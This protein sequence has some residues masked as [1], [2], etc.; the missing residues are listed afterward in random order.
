MPGGNTAYEQAMADARA[1]AAAAARQ[2]NQQKAQ[3]S[4]LAAQRQGNIAAANKARQAQAQRVAI[5][6]SQAENAARKAEQKRQ[7]QA[8]SRSA[9]AKRTADRA[10][11]RQK[12]SDDRAEAKREADKAEER[13]KDRDNERNRQESNRATRERNER[14]NRIEANEFASAQAAAANRKMVKEQT[15]GRKAASDKRIADEKKAAEKIKADAAAR[16]KLNMDLMATLMGKQGPRRGSRGLISDTA[17]G[18]G[19]TEILSQIAQSKLKL[20]SAVNRASGKRADEAVSTQDVAGQQ[21]T[22]D[23]KKPGWYSKDARYS[24][25]QLKE[26]NRLNLEALDRIKNSK[27]VKDATDKTNNAGDSKDATSSTS[28]ETTTG[29]EYSGTY[30]EALQKRQE[31]LDAGDKVEAKKWAIVARR[32]GDKKPSLVRGA[33]DQQIAKGNVFYGTNIPTAGYSKEQIEHFNGR[34]KADLAAGD[35]DGANDAIFSIAYQKKGLGVTAGRSQGQGQGNPSVGA[36][37]SGVWKLDGGPL[38]AEYNI[39]SSNDEYRMRDPRTGMLTGVV[40]RFSDT[41]GILKGTP[42]TITNNRGGTE[43][44]GSLLIGDD[45]VVLTDEQIWAGLTGSTAVTTSSGDGTTTVTD[46]D[47]LN[48]I[49]SLDLAEAKDLFGK[50]YDAESEGILDVKSTA[51]EVAGLTDIEDIKN[52]EIGDEA[53]LEKRMAKLLEKGGELIDAVTWKAKMAAQQAGLFNSL[54]AEQAGLAAVLSEVRAIAKVDAD[55]YYGAYLED[56]KA[57]RDFQK[58]TYTTEATVYREALNRAHQARQYAFARSWDAKNNLAERKWKTYEKAIDRTHTERMKN[59]GF[60]VQA[61]QLQSACAV[62]AKQWYGES[63]SEWFQRW[64]EDEV[65]E[66]VYKQAVDRLKQV[67]DSMIMSCK[68]YS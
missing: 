61:G 10:A 37:Q 54:G 9:A 25:D 19:K 15:E 64:G 20:A 44:T 58:T 34:L 56:A 50:D 57:V 1:K 22:A 30:T 6:K 26:F 5:Q 41:K 65:S 36:V 11:S 14:E 35:Y 53:I 60:D 66:D 55:H 51:Q 33:N 23:G 39:N 3:A 24:P 47:I 16:N 48:A 59:Q 17:V 4:A 7:S 12:A 8:A 31:A 29:T 68:T 21:V 32:E 43:A 28:E 63:E 2:R 45:G 42:T 46:N 13:A 67:F 27:S 49:N 38:W 18:G 40:V 52:I 62:N